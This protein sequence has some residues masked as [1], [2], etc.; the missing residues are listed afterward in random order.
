MGVALVIVKQE[1]EDRIAII[2]IAGKT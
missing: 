2:A 1:D